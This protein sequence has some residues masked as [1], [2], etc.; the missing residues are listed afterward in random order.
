M[1]Q[2]NL[3]GIIFRISE[4]AYQIL[5]DYRLRLYRYFVRQPDGEEILAD[6]EHHI[7][8][9]FWEITLLNAHA[10]NDELVRNMIARMGE[11]ADFEE[12]TQDPAYSLTYQEDNT[13]SPQRQPI[14]DTP[15]PARRS[16]AFAPYNQ[17]IWNFPTKNS[18]IEPVN[19]TYATSDAYQK[20]L[21]RDSKR[22]ILGGVAA[23][24][25]HYFQ[26]D[27]VWVRLAC[28]SVAIGLIPSPFSMGAAVFMYI[29]LW[30][31]LPKNDQLPEIETGKRLY[32]NFEEKKIG[33]VCAGIAQYFGWK[34]KKVRTIFIISA[35]VGVGLGVYGILWI[36]MPK[37]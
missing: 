22:G 34:K 1:Q 10:I 7:A 18:S 17:E 25:G 28:L 12:A 21:Y 16:L 6:L 5:K 14:F 20:R 9:I 30:A 31:A 19:R 24:F 23:G 26:I 3:I 2:I 29:L 13:E 37:K 36:I 11:I 4:S 33:G 15:L 8:E 32:C 35:V 27:T